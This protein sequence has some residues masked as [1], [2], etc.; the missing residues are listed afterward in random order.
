MDA[1]LARARGMSTLTQDDHRLHVEP[2]NLRSCLGVRD[3]PRTA[4]LPSKA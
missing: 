3:A 1:G 4:V 2:S